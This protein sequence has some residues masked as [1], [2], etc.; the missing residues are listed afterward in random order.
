MR[1]ACEGEMSALGGCGYTDRAGDREAV[2][3]R[4]SVL[5]ILRKEPEP[6]SAQVPMAGSKEPLNPT[7]QPTFKLLLVEHIEGATVKFSLFSL[8]PPLL[9]PTLEVRE[10]VKNEWKKQT[11]FL[12]PR[13]WKNSFE[14]DE[15]LTSH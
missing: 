15:L 2:E 1:A 13:S 9:T 5:G 11:M 4:G 6:V 14:L 3:Q 10:E 12:Y 7:Q 8:I